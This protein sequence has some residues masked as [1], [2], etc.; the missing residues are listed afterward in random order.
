MRAKLLGATFGACLLLLP[1]AA[2]VLGHAELV[3]SDPA[4]GK[5]IPT[6]YTITATFSEVFDPNPARSF[7]SV[8]DADDVEVAHGQ[9]SADDQT[10]M[11]VDVP[12]LE[13]GEYS[14]HWQTTTADD[15]GVARGTFTFNVAP[16]PPSAGP[17]STGLPSATVAPG[18][19]GGGGDEG[20]AEGS[21]KD[22]LL[23]LAIAA[24]AIGAVA[25]FVFARM[26]R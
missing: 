9:V 18:G 24:V 15:N 17:T 22:V 10:V 14:V 6:P 20:Q 16:A 25:I 2:T 12:K 5:T 11:T 7:I 13:P 3:Q 26:R 19:P 1:L 21:G 4:D 8:V 23:A